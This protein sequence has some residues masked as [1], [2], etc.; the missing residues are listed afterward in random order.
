MRKYMSTFFFFF[1]IL[2]DDV[3]SLYDF[4]YLNRHDHECTNCFSR[5]WHEAD[6]GLIHCDHIQL[7]LG[8]LDQA[9]HIPAGV[10]S[11]AH[12]RY[13]F[14]CLS[15]IKCTS[16][17]QP[18]PVFVA[19]LLLCQILQIWLKY[20]LAA[21]ARVGTLTSQQQILQVCDAFIR[22]YVSNMQRLYLSNYMPS[23]CKRID[24]VK[25]ATNATQE[26]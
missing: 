10:R 1:F 22:I 15:K 5:V 6:T 7:A 8:A 19:P 17:V 18:E 21:R 4:Y 26:N 16:C 14:L 12:L 3:T 23:M 2:L 24:V 20:G 11:T 9:W 13:R 25:S